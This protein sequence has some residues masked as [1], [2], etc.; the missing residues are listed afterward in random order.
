MMS[1]NAFEV[2]EGRS[3]LEEAAEII[4]GDR[5]RTHG[6]PARNLRAIA[7]IWT[8]LLAAKLG[9]QRITPQE[10]CLLMAGLKLARASHRPS[11]REHAVDTCGY[12]ALLERC[13]WLDDPAVPQHVEGHTT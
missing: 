7:A 5:E 11:H 4:W 1:R 13:G 10:V 12:M 9:E 8:G 6:D 3:V 2:V